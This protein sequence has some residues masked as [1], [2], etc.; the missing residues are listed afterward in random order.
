MLTS[1]NIKKMEEQLRVLEEN[2][3]NPDHFLMDDDIA[4]KG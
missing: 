1:S 4:Q 3:I 2:I